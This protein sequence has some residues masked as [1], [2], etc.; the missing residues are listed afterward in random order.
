MKIR[1]FTISLLVSILFSMNMIS[2]NATP[3]P[4][5]QTSIPTVTAT[6]TPAVPTKIP[7][8]TPPQPPIIVDRPLEIIFTFP[9]VDVVTKEGAV[10][11]GSFNVDESARRNE[12]NQ[13]NMPNALG[14]E[15]IQTIAAWIN[16]Y[17]GAEAHTTRPTD[18]DIVAFGEK[19]AAV[20]SG[21][22]PCSEV[23]ST[24]YAFDE[25]NITRK[26]EPVQ[27]A[28]FCGENEVPDGVRRIDSIEL[29][30]GSWYDPQLNQELQKF[31]KAED[32]PRF[33]VVIAGGG[34]ETEVI[35]KTLIFKI[36]N[37]FENDKDIIKTRIPGQTQWLERW[38]QKNNG[39]G[40]TK[41]NY[42]NEYYYSGLE[43]A[44]RG[45]KAE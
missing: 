34:F 45:F 37:I 38:I 13:I 20:Q 35:G 10:V 39:S 42:G 11:N 16:W 8:E 1:S 26:M 4:P 36:G 19:L 5:T 28:L 7:T 15:I 43:L 3:V 22:V 9:I 18:E 2:C 12:L 14:G 30:Y 6:S 21:D 17:H 40:T 31:V 29:V 33:T 41:L 27:V 24:V 32:M 44:N 23:V 25:T